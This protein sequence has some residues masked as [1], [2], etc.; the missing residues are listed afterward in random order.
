MARMNTDKMK[1]DDTKTNCDCW[2]KTAAELEGQGLDFSDSLSVLSINYKSN[3]I[4]A[5]RVLPLRKTGA[6]AHPLR[7]RYI[8]MSH[9]PFCGKEYNG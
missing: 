8:V 6:V 1:T 9:C 4:R 7:P 2:E 5:I 3:K